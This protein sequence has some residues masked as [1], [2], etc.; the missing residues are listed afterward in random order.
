M[1][2]SELADRTGVTIA[3]VKYYIRIGL[4]HPGVAQSATRAEYDESHVE[5]VL[6]VRT[7]VD[8]GGLS[9][10]RITAVVAA[11]DHPPA[12]RARGAPC[13]R[14]LSGLGLSPAARRRHRAHV[15]A[16]GPAR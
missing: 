9:I 15:S 8:V 3:S 6:F 11:L 14:P 7:L 2:V 12:S 5:R 10:E 13:P 4:L 1:R 16:T